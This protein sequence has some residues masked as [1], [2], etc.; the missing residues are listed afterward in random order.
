LIVT[1]VTSHALQQNSNLKI[2]LNASAGH[3]KRCGRPHAAPG[4]V[5]GPHCLNESTLIC[6]LLFTHCVAC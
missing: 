5:V 1:N 6:S 4:P 2:F 3:R